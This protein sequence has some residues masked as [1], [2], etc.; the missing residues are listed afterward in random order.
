VRIIGGPRERC[1]VSAAV[2]IRAMPVFF[3]KLPLVPVAVTSLVPKV[4]ETLAVRVNV[5]EVVEA[6][7]LNDAVTPVGSPPAVNVT[8]PLKPPV[9]TTEIV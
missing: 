9:G 8:L 7:G 1:A 6:V 4:A 3:T 5:V 2:I